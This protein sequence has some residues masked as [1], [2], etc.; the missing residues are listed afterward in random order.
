VL[1]RSEVR[2]RGLHLRDDP[3]EGLDPERLLDDVH[4]ED[5]GPAGG[6]PQLSG[7]DPQHR[8]LASAVR[9]EE[10]EELPGLDAQVDVLEGVG[11]PIPLPELRR[12]NGRPA[13]AINPVVPVLLTEIGIMLGAKTPRTATPDMVAR[14]A[15]V[16]TFGCL[17]R[18]PIGAKEKADDWPIPGA[19][20]KTMDELRGI[21]DELRRRV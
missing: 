8:R 15:R 21:R 11:V 13:A 2:G 12:E 6:R 1:E 9:P 10:T 7:E 17:D 16:V 19:T 20:G 14:A 4:V 5:V 18:C 3:H